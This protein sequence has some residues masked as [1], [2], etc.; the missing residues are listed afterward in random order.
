M[1]QIKADEILFRASRNGQVM[2]ES[3]TKGEVLGATT[4]SLLKTIY[5]ELMFDRHY[6]FSSKYTEKGKL[7]EESGITL[8]SR[9]KKR[10]LTKNELNLKNQFVSGTPDTFV[11]KDIMTTKEGADIKC[12]WDLTTFPFPTDKLDKSYYWQNIT[13]MALTGA[14]IW[15]TA[16]CLI[17]TPSGM[18][19]DEKR[20]WQYKLGVIDP[21]ADPTFKEKCKEIERNMIFDLGE[22]REAYPFYPLEWD[23]ADWTFDIPMHQRVVEF[24]V[25]R[26]N[27]EIKSLY[28]KIALCRQWMR[29]N[30]EGVI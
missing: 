25:H 23:D 24:T 3:R 2:T 19:D 22:F 18:I 6:E 30:L 1:K 16:F 10:F 21:D 17:N 15:H 26:D 14:D 20:K 8:Y 12:S 4:L 11:G 9:V 28:Q 29:E 7:V 5:R 13:Y 27:E